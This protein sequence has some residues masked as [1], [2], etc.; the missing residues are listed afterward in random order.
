LENWVPDYDA[1]TVTKLKE[2]GAILLGKLGMHELSTRHFLQCEIRG[3]RNTS[4][5]GRVVAAERR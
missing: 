5:A 2:A 1:T 4:R 3:T